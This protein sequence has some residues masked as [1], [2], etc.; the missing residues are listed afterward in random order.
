MGFVHEFTAF[1]E[2]KPGRLAKICSA[3][4][5]EK[6]DLKA[7]SVMDTNGRSVLRFV[8]D[9]VEETRRVLTSL[10]TEFQVSEILAVEIEDRPGA[11][12]RVL[13]RLA[14]EHI[15]I[16]YAYSASSPAPGRSL[17]IFHTSNPRRAQQVLN[18][19][20]GA[21]AGNSPQRRPLHSR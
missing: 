16:E 4:A 5:H 3:L 19:P 15:N 10:G 17:G 7:L 2:N 6:V 1:L 21:G 12:A 13:E 20:T 18:E 14:E 8:T 9:R 11:L